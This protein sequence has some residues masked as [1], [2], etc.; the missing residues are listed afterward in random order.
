MGVNAE[1]AL[2]EIKESGLQPMKHDE[3]DEELWLRWDSNTKKMLWFE[4]H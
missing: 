2:N 4:A 3:H 1:S